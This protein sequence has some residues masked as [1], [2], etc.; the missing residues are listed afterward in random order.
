MGNGQLTHNVM[1]VSG[2]H[3]RD[4]AVHIHVAFRL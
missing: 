3:Q 4:S 1:I 2:E